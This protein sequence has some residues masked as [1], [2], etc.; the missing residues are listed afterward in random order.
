M[1]AINLFTYTRIN[2]DLSTIFENVLVQRSKRLK[3]KKHEFDTLVT[4]VNRLL[5][6]GASP[7]AFDN[8]FV[9]YTIEQI[10]KEFDL[11]KIS[12]NNQVLNIELKSDDVGEEN[13]QKQLRKNR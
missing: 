11:L 6:S 8:F 13:I 2:N 7:D 4:L 10:G 12:E 3:V 5:E 9:S 1:R